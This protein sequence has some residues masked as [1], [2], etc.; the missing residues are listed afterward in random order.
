M[1]YLPH[2]LMKLEDLKGSKKLK[3]Y[4]TLDSDLEL[5]IQEVD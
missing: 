4:Y 1:L 5:L 3:M 2:Q